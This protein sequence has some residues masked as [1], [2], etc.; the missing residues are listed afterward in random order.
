MTAI[1]AYPDPRL[2]PVARRLCAAAAD[3]WHLG[4]ATYTAAARGLLKLADEHDPLR[5]TKEGTDR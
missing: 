2:E 3:R 5:N 1:S 4:H